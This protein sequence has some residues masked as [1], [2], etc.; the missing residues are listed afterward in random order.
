MPQSKRHEFTQ[1]KAKKWFLRE[2]RFLKIERLV[3]RIFYIS[4]SPA[5]LCVRHGKHKFV[6]AHHKDFRP[7]VHGKQDEW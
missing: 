2:F 4:H 7:E 5:V 3:G 1:A 6:N